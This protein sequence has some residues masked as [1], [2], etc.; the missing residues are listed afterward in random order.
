M[1]EG[2]GRHRNH[3]VAAALHHVEGHAVVAREHEEPLGAFA[4]DLLDLVDPPRRLLD[5]DDVRKVAGDAQRRS[6]GHVH[7]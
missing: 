3:A 1:R 6:G 4:E 5:A 2:V 7:P